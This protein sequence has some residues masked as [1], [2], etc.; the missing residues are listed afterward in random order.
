MS[1]RCN[2]CGEFVSHAFARVFGQ[3]GDLAACPQCT[4]QREMS[5]GEGVP[6]DDG[7]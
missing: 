4:K 2:N 7:E 3:D 5:H 1:P 6:G